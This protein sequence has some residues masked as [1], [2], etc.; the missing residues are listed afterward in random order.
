[1]QRWVRQWKRFRPTIAAGLAALLAITIGC[2]S[3]ERTGSRDGV[4]AG[5]EESSRSG[6]PTT[7]A[8]EW[9]RTEPSSAGF[10]PAV[11]EEIAAAA[12][13]TDSNYL[14]VARNGRL[15]ADWY[16]NGTDRRSPQEV[17]SVTKSLTSTLVGIAEDRGDLE[18]DDR[19]AQHVPDWR[20][21]PSAGVTVRNLLSNDSGREWAVPLDYGDLIRAPDKNRFAIELGQEHEPGTVWAY[22]NS[23]IQVLDEVLTTATGLDTADFAQR[24][25]FDAIGMDDSEMIRDD[26]GNT[27]TFMGLQSTCED[28]ARFG[29]LVLNEGRWGDRQVVS[30]EWVRAATGSASQDLAGS[31]GLLWWLNRPG[32]QVGAR[33]ATGAVGAAESEEPSPGQLAEGAPEDMYWALG[34]GGQV[35]AVDPGSG[36]VVVRLGTVVP[37]E[38]AGRFG[39]ADAAEVVTRALVRP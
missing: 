12:G 13:A 1:M 25:L 5:P 4:A 30:A 16:W 19:V 27:L 7:P 32:S 33:S 8:E 14:L 17:F 24:E 2:S 29:H 37:E 23:A 18:I 28:I 6:G 34:L 9:E 39:P 3:D 10:D 31:Y 21:G 11:L 35:L 15:V 22:N 20:D 38:G 26:A 36:T